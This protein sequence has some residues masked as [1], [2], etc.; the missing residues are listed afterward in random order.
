MSLGT[1]FVTTFIGLVVGTI[2]VD[3]ISEGIINVYI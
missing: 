3:F 1:L 2:I